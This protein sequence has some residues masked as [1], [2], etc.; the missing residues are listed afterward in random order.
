MAEEKQEGNEKRITV[1]KIYVKDFS[2]ESP[3]A[4]QVFRSEKWA[5][6]TNL[7]LRSSQR[8]LNDSLYEV[9]LTIT[10]DAKEGD[11]TVF[12]VEIQQAGLFE[13]L[14]YDEAERAAI[15]GSYCPGILFPYAREAVA[16]TIQRGGFPE[17][18]LQ[19][20]N[21]D[22]LYA[23]SQKQAAAAAAAKEEKH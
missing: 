8:K 14:G 18:V 4:P 5:P 20:I 12:L 19:P 9:V 23:Q 2:F 10:V 15:T 6:Q 7:N 11:K 22:A 21:F 13:L 16:S 3:Q 17:F 1:V